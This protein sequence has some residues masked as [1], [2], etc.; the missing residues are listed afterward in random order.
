MTD[1]VR[2]IRDD[3]LN[4]P[5]TVC[6]DRARLVTEAWRAHEHEPAPIRRALMLQYLLRHMRLDLTSN[7]VFAGN[8]SAKPQAWMLVPEHGIGIAAQVLVENSKIDGLLDGAV[9]AELQEFWRERAFGGLS[10]IGHLAVDLN[11]VVHDGLEALLAE[12]EAPHDGTPEQAA[13]RRAMAIGL[14]AVIA[15]AGRYAEA[16]EEAARDEK[17]PLRRACLERVARAC[18]RVPA[19]PAKDLFEGLQAIALVH[20]A[21]A[22]EG[23]GMSVSIGSPDRVLEPFVGPDTDLDE[24]TALLAAF[25]LK[26]TANSLFG[27]GYLSQTIT[28]GGADQTGRDRCNAL[29]RCFLDA[30]DL[31]RVGDPPVFLRWHRGLP[32][33]LRQRAAELLASGLSMPLLIHDAPTVA[34]FI[35]NGVAPR[36]AWDYCVIGCNELGIPGRAADSANAMSG[37]IQHLELLCWTLLR[38]EE[39]DAIESVEQLLEPFAAHLTAQAIR[40]RQRGQEQCRRLAEVLPTPFTSALMTGCIER[41]GDLLTSAR[42]HTPCAYERGV[43]N[44]ANALAAI[45]QLVFEEGSVTLREL[46]AAM[47][48]DFP[49][50]TLQTALRAA[51]KWGNDDLRVDRWVLRLLELREAAMQQ[52]DAE[53]D[54]APHAVCHVVRSLHFLDGRTIGASPDGRSAGRPVADSIGAEVGTAAN[55]P[56]ATLQSVLKIDAARYYRGGYNLNLTL[57]PESTTPATVLALVD[58]FFGAGGQELQLNCYDAAT[59]RKAQDRP[60]AYPDL[61]VRVAGFSG[62][63]IDLSKPEQDELIARAEPV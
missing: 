5:D 59:L 22:L 16:A 50:T 19:K 47:R 61:I 46:V 34:G 56:T 60:E 39:P 62:R 57:S 15:W 40:Q 48:E 27:S 36:D 18:H 12:A 42:Y 38:L 30:A 20:L 24:A 26:L 25:M 2:Q 9:P 4:T 52:A 49:V 13:Y 41:G 7:P 63:F 17:D 29:T 11:R 45:E 10:G 6:L 51:P 8:T 53:S 43:T 21:I 14:R 3:L 55:G 54:G 23:H 1:L 31:A 28:V 35:A 58:G 37:T 33:D 44:A 32:D